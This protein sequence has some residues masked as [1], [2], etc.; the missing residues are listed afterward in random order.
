MLQC[1]LPAEEAHARATGQN[2][3]RAVAGQV[4][5]ERTSRVPLEQE[6][7]MTPRS[8]SCGHIHEERQD[9]VVGPP[10]HQPPA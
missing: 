7:L 10:R 4:A 1:C 2:E 3:A 8:E 6:L 5:D 9:T